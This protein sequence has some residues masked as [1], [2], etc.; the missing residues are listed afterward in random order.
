MAYIGPLCERRRVPMLPPGDPPQ[1]PAPR[2]FFEEIL[3]VLLAEAGP[4][5]PAG[6]LGFRL[7][8]EPT[9]A[10]TVDLSEGQ[11]RAGLEDPLHLLLEMDGEDFEAMLEGKLDLDVALDDARIRARGDLELL[12]RFGALLEDQG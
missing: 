11:V 10:W 2:A 9:G 1:A 12:A 4:G 8:G 6:R 7:F 5:G 3:P